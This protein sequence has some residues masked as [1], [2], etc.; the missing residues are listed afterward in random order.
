MMPKKMAVLTIGY[1]DYAMSVTDAMTIMKIAERAIAVERHSLFSRF[2]PDE[3][4]DEPFATRMEM[5]IVET[6]TRKKLIPESHRITYDKN[7]GG[8]V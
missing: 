1:R 5:A 7:R 2:Q 3:R 4:G 8:N 6:P